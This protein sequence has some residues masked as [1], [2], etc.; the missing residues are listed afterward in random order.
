MQFAATQCTCAIG[1][2]VLSAP[3]RK[4]FI[5]TADHETQ[6]NANWQKDILEMF[7]TLRHALN[8]GRVTMNMVR[9]HYKVVI[10]AHCHKSVPVLIL[11]WVLLV[12]KT[13]NEQLK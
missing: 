9:Q 6:L 10:S 2:C 7:Q 4:A 11:T 12:H 13:T 3:T 5:L 1:G 8:T